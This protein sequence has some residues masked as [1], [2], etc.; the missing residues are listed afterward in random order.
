MTRP[1]ANDDTASTTEDAAV[2]GNVLANDTDVD[3]EPLTV[4]TPGTYVGAYG[5]LVLAADGSYT[6]TPSAAAQGLDDGEVVSDSFGYT[7]SDGTASDTATLTVNVSG[8]NDAPVANDDTAS[9]TEDLAASGNVLAN[10][11]D[12][13]VEPLTVTNPGTYVGTYGTLVLAANG[14]YT[15]TPN[16]AAQGL[17]DGE[18]VSDS[19]GYTASDG[20]AS[21]TAHAHRHGQ[22]P[23]R[24]AGGQ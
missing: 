11:T 4:T 13:D 12:V 24:R 15:Y 14:S 10:D 17:D 7:A 2:S 22:R 23:Q 1:V 21:D 6:Y 5:T 3:V 16:A 8:L 20:T 19:F 18:V 9:T